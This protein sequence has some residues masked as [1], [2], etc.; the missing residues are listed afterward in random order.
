MSAHPDPPTGLSTAT[1]PR[2]WAPHYGASPK[3]AVQRF[4]GKYATTS[5]RASRSE[6]WWWVLVSVAVISGLHLLMTAGG[7][8][9]PSTGEVTAGQQ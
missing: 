9:S 2:D 5:G 1:K 6:Y 3:A 8:I 4:F 7:G